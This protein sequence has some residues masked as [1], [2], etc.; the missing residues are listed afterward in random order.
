MALIHC[1]E[2]SKQVSSTAAACPHCGFA[3]AYHLQEEARKQQQVEQLRRRQQLIEK[4]QLLRKTKQEES[5]EKRKSKLAAKKERTNH[6]N[7]FPRMSLLILPTTLLWSVIAALLPY[8]AEFIQRKKYGWLI[9][10]K[11]TLFSWLHRNVGPILPGLTFAAFTVFLI[12]A[13]LYIIANNIK[14]LKTAR[15]LLIT[16][17]S[18]SALLLS[19]SVISTFSN[20]SA[21]IIV[22]RFLI[23][24]LAY[25]ALFLSATA[26]RRSPKQAVNSSECTQ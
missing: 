5:E 3:V 21:I 10:E 23:P 17:C 24:F 11:D 8:I 16:C 9:S 14:K 15:I 19:G 20:E 4:K 2:C 6:L 7:Q 13:V 1:P 25:I 22:L 12:P 18:Y 26:K